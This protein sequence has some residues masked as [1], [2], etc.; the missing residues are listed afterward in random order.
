M[1]NEKKKLEINSNS[2]KNTIENN[3]NTNEEIEKQKFKQLIYDELLFKHN[4][5][6]LSIKY[7]YNL[8]A[9]YLNEYE[10]KEG[11]EIKNK[12]RRRNLRYLG[13]L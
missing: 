1:M 10:I 4:T 9:K 2:S 6:L 11:V 8:I 13:K 5:S 7:T 12:I 3:L